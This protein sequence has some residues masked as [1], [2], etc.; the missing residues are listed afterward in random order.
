MKKLLFLSLLITTIFGLT[1][2]T[3]INPANVTVYSNDGNVSISVPSGWNTSDTTIIPTAMIGASNAAN[4]EYVIV[5]GQLQSSLGA[6][7]TINDY[8]SLLEK[9]SVANISNGIW[10]N[11]SKVT[12]DGLNGLAFRV[13]GILRKD[14]TNY[15]FLF[16]VLANNNYYYAIVGFTNT[17]LLPAN[18]AT[19]QTIINSFKAPETSVTGGW[20]PYTFPGS[21]ILFFI[22]LI[23]AGELIFLGRRLRNRIPVPHPGRVLKIVIIAIWAVLM[24]FYLSRVIPAFFTTHSVSNI[25]LG[26]IFP[27][28]FGCAVVTFIYVAYITRR[29]GIMAALR[30]GFVAFAAGPMIFEFPFDMIVIPQIKAPAAFLIAYFGILD[31]SVLFTLALLMLLKRIYVTKMSIY[32]LG[33]MFIVFAVWALFGF[34]Y[35][36][37]P[38]S[39]TLNTISKV[40]GFVTVVTLFSTEPKQITLREINKPIE[41]QV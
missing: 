14:N 11:P 20:K 10:G 3:G 34:A 9:S 7:S 1:A 5:T 24:L 15:T 25:G 22:L 31:V 19:L 2:C 35:P 39:F 27:I 16:N 40:L 30:N 13:T 12:I 18:Q 21:V 29:D 32:T 28:T 26:P 8:L 23:V 37:N 33:A 17:S 36:A 4:H 6:N 38:I 41:R